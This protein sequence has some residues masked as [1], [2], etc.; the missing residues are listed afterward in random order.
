MYGEQW[1]QLSLGVK[2]W[3]EIFVVFKRWGT[4]FSVKNMLDMLEI[5]WRI[6]SW[7]IA[8]SFQ[9]RRDA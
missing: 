4:S 5:I 9:A 1:E 7:T 3:V 2:S 8:I 6:L